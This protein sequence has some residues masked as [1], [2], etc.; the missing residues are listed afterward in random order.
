[1]IGVGPGVVAPPR[2]TCK[3]GLG[4][5][6]TELEWTAEVGDEIEGVELDRGA[7]RGVPIPIPRSRDAGMRGF[8][9][10]TRE[11]ELNGDEAGISTGGTFPDSVGKACPKIDGK[12]FWSNEDTPSDGSPILISALAAN[13]VVVLPVI[14]N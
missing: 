4:A 14:T 3:I 13:S 2:L 5:P 9:A 10:G 1:M 7:G 11:L 12:A 8:T 6:R